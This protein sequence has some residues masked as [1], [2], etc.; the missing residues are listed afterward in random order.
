MSSVHHP[1]SD[2]VEHLLRNAQLRTELEPFFD[3]SITRVTSELPTPVENEYLASMLAWEKAPVLPIGQWFEPEL[4]LPSPDR[5]SEDQ[6]C[7]LLRETID[8][9]YSKR[10]VLDYTDHLSDRELYLVVWRD[11]LPSPEKKIDTPQGYLHWNCSAADDEEETW[12][13]YYASEGERQQWAE[14]HGW[15]RELPQR[16]EPPFARRLPRD[17]AEEAS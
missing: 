6:V 2:D 9:L 3:E 4:Q 10:I 11:I 17:P 15:G 14:E 8:K 7:A 5:L 1:Q 12:L 16:E 13:R